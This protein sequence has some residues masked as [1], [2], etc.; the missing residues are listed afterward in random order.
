VHRSQN[1]GARARLSKAAAQR[2][3]RF[4]VARRPLYTRT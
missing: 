1:I 3:A 4:V 2:V